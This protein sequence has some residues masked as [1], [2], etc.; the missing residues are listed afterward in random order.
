MFVS[1]FKVDK[2]SPTFIISCIVKFVNC[3]K[4]I[5]ILT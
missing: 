5:A 4:N 3:F 1:A 2:I